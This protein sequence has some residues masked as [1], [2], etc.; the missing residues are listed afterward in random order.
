MATD[1]DKAARRKAAR[2][3][4]KFSKRAQKDVEKGAIKAGKE[5]SYAIGKDRKQEEVKPPKGK[6]FRSKTKV[7]TIGGRKPE[8]KKVDIPATPGEDIGIEV[9]RGGTGMEQE[10]VADIPKGSEAP[11]KFDVWEGS[12]VPLMKSE[13]D[14]LRRAREDAARKSFESSGKP[15]TVRI[16]D[17]PKGTE[18]DHR[19]REFGMKMPDKLTTTK[20]RGTRDGRSK[21]KTVT[22]YFGKIP[23]SE[24]K[25]AEQRRVAHEARS[26][27][28][29]GRPAM[30]DVKVRGR[31][32]IEKRE[33]QP[34]PTSKWEAAKA[35]GEASR[36]KAK[37]TKKT[38]T[39]SYYKLPKRKRRRR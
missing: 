11:K 39:S 18:L 21:T 29:G 3:Y 27:E 16:Q 37:A 13:K 34:K 23:E 4:S 10:F 38:S 24:K 17:D 9:Y 8:S 26:G 20:R 35:K 15:G 7:L 22:K 6:K 31:K 33:L 14:P 12:G 25:A 5:G 2:R 32:I 30:A 36:E 1:R 28:K 19:R